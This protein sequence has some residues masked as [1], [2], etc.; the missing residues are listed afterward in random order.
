MG[1][2]QHQK[3]KLYLTT[4]EWKEEW[5]GHKGSKRVPFKRLPYHCC[6]IAFTPF[7]DAVCTDD[8]TVF[9]VSNIVPCESR[10]TA[11]HVYCAAW[12]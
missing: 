1:K 5:G 10:E 9:D 11:H 8:G 12:V 3:D 6:A 2:K 4:K 7:E